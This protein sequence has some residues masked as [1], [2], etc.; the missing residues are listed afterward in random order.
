MARGSMAISGFVV[1]WFIA[2]RIVGCSGPDGC[3]SLNSSK[4][5]MSCRAVSGEH[6]VVLN[7]RAL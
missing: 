4:Y 5:V 2:P 1:N 3:K 6:F 7:E